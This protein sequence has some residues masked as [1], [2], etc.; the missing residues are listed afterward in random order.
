MKQILVLL[1]AL[2]FSAFTQVDTLVGSGSTVSFTYDLDTTAQGLD[3]F[4]IRWT[5]FV[6]Y[7]NDLD[8]RSFTDYRF[9]PDTNDF[10]S[11]LTQLQDEYNALL[12]RVQTITDEAELKA[13][14]IKAFENLRDSVIRGMK[15]P[16]LLLGPVVEPINISPQP[17]PKC[18]LL[19]VFRRRK[20]KSKK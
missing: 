2:P 10:N 4:F 7:T 14:R 3:S 18:R 9:F 1:L 5:D 11:Y 13:K 17:V 19:A 20:H 15:L 12:L 6:K 8:S 16:V